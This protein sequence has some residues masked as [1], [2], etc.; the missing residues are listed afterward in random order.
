[1]RLNVAVANPVRTYEGAPARRINGEQQLRRLVM[2]HMLWEDQFYVDGKSAAEQ[3][4]ALAATLPPAV[5][6]NVAIE[7][8]E[9]QKLRHLPLLLAR[10]LARRSKDCEPGL[11]AGLISRLVR[12]PDELAEFLVIYWKDGKAPIAA[13]VKKG[14]A[15]AFRKFDEYQLAKYNRDAAV[16]LRDVLFL[17]HAKPKDDEQAALWKRLVDGTLATP[18][19]WEVALSAGKDKKAEWT[20]LLS[21]NGLGALALL[22]NLRNMQQA[23][24]DD[25]LV[26]RSLRE[27]KPERVL[28]FRFI[29]AARH[30]PTFEPEL[31]AAM[32]TNLEAQERL[33][34]RTILLVDVSGSMDSQVSGKSEISRLDAACGVAMLAREICETARVFTFSTGLCEVAPRRGFALRDAIVRSQP[35]SSTYLGAAVKH[36]SALPHDRL[37]VITDEQS[38]D[39]VPNPAGVGYMVNV[40][41]YQNG[42]GYGPWLRV[43]GWSEAVVDFIR[44]AEKPI[45]AAEQ[46]S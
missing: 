33:P 13:Q 14:L 3:V 7:A 16:K 32:L 18:D 31:E 6:A 20:R 25:L 19:T 17:V 41:A 10:E 2:A 15:A 4:A 11:V 23:G 26:R 9:Q 36:V 38:H 27:M 24:V 22:R 30:A 42:V 1:M 43:D 46:P 35:H 40:A 5:V 44:E 37:I 34:G 39:P 12:R 29:A 21:E 45:L 28:P 8:K